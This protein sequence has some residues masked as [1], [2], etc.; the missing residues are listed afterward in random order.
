MIPRQPE[1]EHSLVDEQVESRVV[2]A[3]EEDRG[4]AF[5]NYSID[6]VVGRLQVVTHQHNVLP[7]IRA[8]QRVV[9]ENRETELLVGNWNAWMCVRTDIHLNRSGTDEFVVCVL[10]HSYKDRPG[11][12]C[13]HTI[14]PN[15]EVKVIIVR[16]GHSLRWVQYAD[17]GIN[18]CGLLSDAR[19][20]ACRNENKDAYP[21]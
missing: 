9:C 21:N 5:H 4:C 11:F 16:K 10:V 6:L 15:H 18:L 12:C 13:E 1:S 7:S 14:E 20:R 17:C 3:I 19:Q 8:V 2:H